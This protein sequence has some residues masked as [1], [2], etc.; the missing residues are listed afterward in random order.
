MI[1]ELTILLEDCQN[2]NYWDGND[3]P[4][5][6][7]GNRKLNPLYRCIVQSSGI[8]LIVSKDVKPGKFDCERDCLFSGAT[9]ECFNN[10]TIKEAKADFIVT[11]DIPPQY[12][13]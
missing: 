10:I 13:F 5:A 12:L 8:F 6:R 7:A 11:I 3:C 4:L 1:T 2:A 9:R